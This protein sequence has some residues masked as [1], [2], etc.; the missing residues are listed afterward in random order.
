[1]VSSCSVAGE[2]TTTTSERAEPVAT[3]MDALLVYPELGY[4]VVALSNLDEPA[5]DN[6][7]DFFTL[8]M[9]TA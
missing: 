3:V 8:R 7:V 9:P 1:V 4:V 5:A 6:V 2:A